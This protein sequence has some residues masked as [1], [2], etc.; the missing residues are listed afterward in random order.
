MGGNGLVRKAVTAFCGSREA[1]Q[2]L[3]IASSGASGWLDVLRRANPDLRLDVDGAAL[4][5]HWSDDEWARGCYSAFD[6]PAAMSRPRLSE[7]VG[8]LA[9]AGEHTS[10]ESATME[11]ALSSGLSAAEQVR[12]FLTT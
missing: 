6:L 3:A 7:A 10:S 2:E 1:Q 5:H 8:R 11:G 4:F 9:F 12:A